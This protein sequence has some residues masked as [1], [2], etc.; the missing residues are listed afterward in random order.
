MTP[1]APWPPQIED[2]KTDLGVS[3]SRDD[4]RLQQVLDAAVGVVEREL[5]GACNFTGAA[6][7]AGEPVLPEPS[8]SV[9]LGTIRYAGRWHSRR[10]SPDGRIDNGEL[11]SARVPGFDPDIERMLG[12]GRFRPP[13]VG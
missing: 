10:Q 3:D 2:L 1:V 9:V 5:E 6:A 12:T 4:F 8:P 13:M 7:A 11:G